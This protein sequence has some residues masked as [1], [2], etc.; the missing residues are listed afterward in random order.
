M[1][2]VEEILEIIGPHLGSNIDILFHIGVLLKK[3]GRE[4]ELVQMLNKE[5][6][7]IG[8]MNKVLRFYKKIA[9]KARKKKWDLWKPPR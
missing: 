5:L 3:V 9:P 6:T 7:F 2:K 8:Y 4:Y 1:A